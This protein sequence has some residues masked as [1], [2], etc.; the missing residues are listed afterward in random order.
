MDAEKLSVML[1][2]VPCM[3]RNHEVCS[4]SSILLGKEIEAQGGDTLPWS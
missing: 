3:Y 2:T 4:V 1:D